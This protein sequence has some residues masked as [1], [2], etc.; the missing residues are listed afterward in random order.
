MLREELI[1]APPAPR[2][3]A[4]GRLHVPSTFG[5]GRGGSTSPRGPHA[6]PPAYMRNLEKGAVPSRGCTSP[7]WND[8]KG[9]SLFV[10]GGPAIVRLTRAGTRLQRVLLPTGVL[11][12]RSWPFFLSIYRWQPIYRWQRVEVAPSHRMKTLH[13]SFVFLIRRAKPQVD[14]AGFRKHKTG[15]RFLGRTRPRS[16]SE[17]SPNALASRPKPS[18]QGLTGP[19]KQLHEARHHG[20]EALCSLAAAGRSRF[21]ENDEKGLSLFVIAS[22]R[23]R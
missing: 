2:A 14:F 11:F 19:N 16:G 12:L 15:E 13:H 10:I 8:E 17:S 1:Y 5:G 4:G 22:P 9:L 6:P 18:R 3:R 20:T 23:P 21:A 7:E